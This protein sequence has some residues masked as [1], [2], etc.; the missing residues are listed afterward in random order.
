MSNKQ[1]VAPGRST[2]FGRAVRQVW[3]DAFAAGRRS[4][5]EGSPGPADRQRGVALLLALTAIAILC[6]FSLQFTYQARVA[7]KTSTYVESEVEAYLHARAAVELAALVIGSVDIVESILNKYAQMM[8]GRRPTINTAAYACEFVNAFCKGNMTLMGIELVSLEGRP[9]VG[10]ARGTCGC[11]SGDEDGRVNVNRSKTLPEKQAVFDTLYKVLERNEG[12]ARP[13]ELDKEMA[14]LAL[15]IIDWSDADPNKSDVDPGTRK[16]IEGAG[17]E[18]SAYARN[19]L[20]VKDAPFDTTEEVR[21]VEGMTDQ[22]WCKLRDQLT[23]YNTEKL[24]INTANIE[25]IKALIC[26]NLANPA[27]EQVACARGYDN[28]PFVPV[29]VAGQYI[30]VCRTLKKM[31]MSPAF[32]SPAKFVQFFDKLGPVLGAIEGG[33]TYAQVL[34]INHAR[35]LED[36]GTSG[37]I[38][39][40]QAYGTSGKVQKKITAL[41]D[42][43][44]QRYVYWRED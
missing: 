5:G 18:G 6:V 3:A 20:K 43:T 32:A 28:N 40:I 38:V 14:Q 11:T 42:T 17:S 4:V 41:L 33:T 44:S 19:G 23:V 21:L 31:I 27:N 12:M 34:Q 39:R 15:N 10:L 24:N 16:L 1:A 35:M 2:L 22:M 7:V 26:K 36:I 30:E 29:N 9:G 37:K 8:Q 25:V 13:G